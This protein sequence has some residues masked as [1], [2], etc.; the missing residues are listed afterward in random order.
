[1]SDLAWSSK[2]TA[3]LGGRG[4]ATLAEIEPEYGV[5][6]EPT[7]ILS[8]GQLGLKDLDVQPFRRLVRLR[9]AAE[10]RRNPFERLPVVANQFQRCSKVGGNHILAGMLLFERSED[11]DRH[12]CIAAPRKGHGIV[13][14]L[15][16]VTLLRRNP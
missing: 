8:H 14:A 10:R 3:G 5:R 7:G 4:P 9:I 2:S 11:F 1:M 16:I 6:G 12:G 15:A 13:G